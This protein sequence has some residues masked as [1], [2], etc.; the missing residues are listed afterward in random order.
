MSLTAN[1]RLM[2]EDFMS[3]FRFCWACG[4]RDRSQFG[5][6]NAHIVGASGRRADRRCIARLCQRCHTLNHGATIKVDGARLPNL[7]LLCLL[8]LKQEFD[9]DYY[10]PVFLQS[11]RIQSAEVLVPEEPN[12]WFALQWSKRG[13]V[14]FQILPWVELHVNR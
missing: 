2:Y 9:P 12:K 6:Q 13:A 3:E 8:W 7:P 14:P 1:E 5:L 11:L 10:D 4:D